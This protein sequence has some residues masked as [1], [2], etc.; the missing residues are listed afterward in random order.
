MDIQTNELT[1]D[2]WNDLE[3]LFGT[4]G[5]CGGC[6]CMYWRLPKGET[7]EDL[8]GDIAKSRLKRGVKDSSILGVLAYVDDAPVGWCAFGPRT[9]F[10]KLDR[11]PSFRCDDAQQVWSVPCFYVKAGFR[12]K[13]VARALLKQALHLMQ[14]RGVKL[15]EGYPSKPNKDGKY[16]NAFAWTGTASLFAKEGFKIVGNRDGG[17]QRVRKQLA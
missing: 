3:T 16:I 2:R 10:V 13:G 6:W 1:A 8:K 15:V 12:G 11:A 9:E 17:K 7:W 5:A 4:N 14:G